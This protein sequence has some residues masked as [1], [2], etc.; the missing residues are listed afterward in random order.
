M[1]CYKQLDVDGNVLYLIT[2]DQQPNITAPLTVA[3]SAEEYA[4]LLAEI[5]ASANETAVPSDSTIEDKAAA[6]DILTGA[7]T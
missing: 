4:T 1:Y 3:I 2:Y 7:T 6:Y 5:E